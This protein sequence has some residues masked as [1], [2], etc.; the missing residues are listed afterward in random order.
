MLRLFNLIFF[1]FFELISIIF[2]FF[3]C[4]TEF[5]SCWH[6]KQWSSIRKHVC[7]YYIRHVLLPQYFAFRHVFLIAVSFARLNV[8]S[9]I[10]YFSTNLFVN[11]VRTRLHCSS[12]RILTMNVKEEKDEFRATLYSLL[13]QFI[14]FL[15][16]CF[17][18]TFGCS[19]AI[20]HRLN[21]L[22]LILMLLLLLL[23]ILCF[24]PLFRCR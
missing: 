15:S 21:S 20:F 1:F 7:A 9:F 12:N 10:C 3:K 2:F 4:F 17:T 22:K 24:E 16:S 19:D 6:I 11:S 14:H 23:F 5:M 18:C 13:H 8:T